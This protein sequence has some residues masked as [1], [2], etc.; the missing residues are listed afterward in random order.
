[1]RALFLVGD[2][3]E[4][5]RSRVPGLSLSTANGPLAALEEGGV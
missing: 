5:K 2:T 1:V 4:E 3:L